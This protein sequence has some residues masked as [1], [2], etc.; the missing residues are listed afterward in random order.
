[1]YVVFL[2][3]P[4]VKSYKLL[5]PYTKQVNYSMEGLTLGSVYRTGSCSGG[6]GNRKEECHVSFSKVMWFYNSSSQDPQECE[7]VSPLKRYRLAGF[8]RPAYEPASQ[9]PPQKRPSPPPEVDLWSL[10]NKRM[11]NL[12]SLFAC[13]R[14]SYNNASW[15]DQE[16]VCPN[17]WGCPFIK[18]IFLSLHM[19][20]CK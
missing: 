2:I 10:T 17:S 11:Q 8:K 12:V 18:R 7:E 14:R 19:R 4:V 13:P 5:L 20:V 9:S 15:Q 3:S 1:M 6:R 16:A